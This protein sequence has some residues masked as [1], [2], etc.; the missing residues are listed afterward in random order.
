MILLA[1]I[2]Y[3]EGY[4]QESAMGKN[5]YV[6]NAAIIAG[7]C[8]ALSS[9]TTVF[10]SATHEN[11]F[12]KTGNLQGGLIVHAGCGDGTLIAALGNN[13]Q[14]VI[15]GLEKDH[16]RVERARHT[17]RATGDY[18]RL[19]IKHWQGPRLPYAENQVNLLIIDDGDATIIGS[20][21]KRVLTPRGRAVVHKRCKIRIGH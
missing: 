10:A 19:S 4:G 6:I 2:Y 17:V 8:I 9:F 11:I 13:K 14:Y 3:P 16:K 7:M 20:E 18:G 5:H 12:T 15:Q 1:G 21:I